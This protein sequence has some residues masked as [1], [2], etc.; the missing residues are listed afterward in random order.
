MAFLFQS[1]KK[2]AIAPEP[3]HAE[4]PQL[5]SAEMSAVYYGQRRAGDFYDF[6]SVGHQRTLFG[7]LD[8]AGQRDDNRAIL[9]A[10]QTTFRSLALELFGKEELNEA[11]AMIE[12]GVQLNRTIMH[13]ERG[14]RACPAF[15]GCYHEGLGTVC[16][17]NAGHTPGLLRDSTG[18]TELPATGLPLGLFS[19]LTADAPVVALESGA[20]LLLVSRGVVDSKC[21]A[22]EFGLGR[23]KETI[24]NS[25]W[26]TPKE[27]CAMVIQDVQQ[28][29]CKPPTHDD[30]TVLALSRA[31]KAA[32]VAQT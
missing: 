11:D 5:E 4:I 30:V 13:A 29:M 24:Q 16:Y 3:V 1:K 15:A 12:L 27:L 28:F 22:E 20:T 31:A 26:Q 23:V 25:G 6:V 21:K 17:F 8:V 9:N 2:P 19:H 32:A 10:A 14:V 7:L 18:I